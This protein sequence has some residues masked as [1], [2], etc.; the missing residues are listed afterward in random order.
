[1]NRQLRMRS[2]AR[3]AK[4]G[5]PFAVLFNDQF[6]RLSAPLEKRYDAAEV[7]GLLESA[8]LT[9]VRVFARYGWIGEGVRPSA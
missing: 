1:V 4:R 6:D 9:D 7:C 5:C 8:G 2:F 3:H